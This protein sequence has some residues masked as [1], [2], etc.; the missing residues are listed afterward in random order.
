MTKTEKGIVKAIASL[1]TL[2]A[3]IGK[4]HVMLS[5]LVIQ[6]LPNLTEDEKSGLLATIENSWLQVQQLQDIAVELKKTV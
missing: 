3:D 4:S 1:A 5:N 6:H 2:T